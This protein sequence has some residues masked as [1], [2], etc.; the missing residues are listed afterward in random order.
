MAADEPLERLAPEPPPRILVNQTVNYSTG[1]VDSGRWNSTSC[2][3]ETAEG[4]PVDKKR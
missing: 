3:Q 4:G 1:P 2:Q